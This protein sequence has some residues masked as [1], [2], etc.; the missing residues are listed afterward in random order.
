MGNKATR[1]IPKTLGVFDSSAAAWDHRVQVGQAGNGMSN[2]LNLMGRQRALAMFADWTDRIAAGEVPP[3]PPRPQ[4]QERNVVVTMWDYGDP[5]KYTHDGNSTDKRKPTVNA[6]GPIYVAPEES[7]DDLYVVD[8]VRNTA[9]ALTVPV[10][11]PKTPV[12]PP[13]EVHRLAVLG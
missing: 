3:T 11:D 12:R 2:G 10:R 1:E 5:T 9:S 8:P 4:G 7:S 6:N 13:A